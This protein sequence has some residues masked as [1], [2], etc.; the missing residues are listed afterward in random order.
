MSDK[1]AFNISDDFRAAAALGLYTD[2]SVV[3]G[4]AEQASITA[5]VRTIIGHGGEYPVLPSDTGEVLELNNTNAGN[6]GAIILIDALDADFRPITCTVNLTATI[7]YVRVKHPV[8]GED[9]LITRINSAKNYGDRGV[10]ELEADVPIVDASTHAKTFG[11][12]RAA[13]V[14]EMQQA[15]FSV[16]RGVKASV[17]SMTLSLAKSS[18]TETS[19]DFRLFGAQVGKVFRRVFKFGLQRGGTSTQD[20]VN[21]VQNTFTGPVDL[22]LSAESTSS[23]ASVAGRITLMYAKI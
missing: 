23:G 17:T 6:A 8:T 12:I 4:F 10:G 18:G 9:A 21:A 2:V 1:R 15:I 3:E 16:P 5:D 13:A 7:G 22:F 20:L 14:Q 19:V 11:T